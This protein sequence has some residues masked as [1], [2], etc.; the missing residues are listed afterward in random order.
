VAGVAQDVTFKKTM[1]S[2]VKQPTEVEVNLLI[3]DSKILI[4][5]KKVSKNVP[6]IDLEI[7]Y[8]SIDSMSYELASRHRVSEGAAVAAGIS[9]G[10]GA[11]LMGTK[12]KSYWLT[13]EYHE[14]D[15]NQSPVL[16]LD[17]SEY[18]GVIATL[19]TKTG[20]HIAVLDTKSRLPNQNAESKDMDEVIP[21]GIDRVAAALKPAMENMGC[22]VMNAKATRIACKRGRGSSER[23][24]YSG[25][26][27]VTAR[28]EARGEQTRVL[29]WTGK[30]FTAQV[31]KHNWSTPIYQEMMKSLQ[32]PA[33]ASFLE[34]RF[35]FR[36]D[37]SFLSP[38]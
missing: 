30:K 27:K 5:S 12:T 38:A 23:S 13:I 3:T 4:K 28:L 20:K 10:A 16:H 21:F 8:S 9:L 32:E 11:I 17:K 31:G 35:K 22:K 34:P 33:R 14:G 15:S 19:E 26:E 2:S 24:D 18:K 7:P 6:M 25:G 29:I 36:D 1:Y 37:I